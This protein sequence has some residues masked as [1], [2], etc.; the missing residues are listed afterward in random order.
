[1]DINAIASMSTAMAT[2]RVQNEVGVRVLK[3]AQ[4]MQ[5][6]VATSLLSSAVETANEIAKMNSGDVGSRIDVTA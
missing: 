5:G 3:M 4:D 2:A 1:M 6:Q